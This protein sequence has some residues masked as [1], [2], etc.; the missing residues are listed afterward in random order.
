[1]AL[2]SSQLNGD[3]LC[4]GLSLQRLR[5]QRVR[6]QRT[7]PNGYKSGFPKWITCFTKIDL[8]WFFLEKKPLFLWCRWEQTGNLLAPMGAK[9]LCWCSEHKIREVEIIQNTS[10]SSWSD[11]FIVQGVFT[12]PVVTFPLNII[13]VVKL[14][15]LFLSLRMSLLTSP[16]WAFIISA[17]VYT[18]S[19]SSHFI[20]T[21]RLGLMKPHFLGLITPTLCDIMRN[22]KWQSTLWYLSLPSSPPT[23]GDVSFSSSPCIPLYISPLSFAWFFQAHPPLLSERRLDA[24]EA[25]RACETR[26]VQANPYT[27]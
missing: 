6:A 1:M 9:A 13:F 12:S 25:L 8:I 20:L 14:L 27:N 19:I 21:P 23:V 4:S 26:L 3:K 5:R 17:T 2:T 7:A 24:T 22:R 16:H 18:W 11:H 15:E 10:C